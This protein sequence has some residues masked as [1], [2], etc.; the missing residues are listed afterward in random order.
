MSEQSR[1]KSST[2]NPPNRGQA[3]PTD[4]IKVESQRVWLQPSQ[5]WSS[6][7]TLMLLVFGLLLL[8]ALLLSVFST[9]PSLGVSSQSASTDLDESTPEN[10]QPIE[11]S[12]PWQRQREAQARVDAQDILSEMLNI[13]KD[14]EEV[15]VQRWA[16]LQYQAALALA[17]SGD[18]SYK[19][20]AYEE[21]L[22]Q[23]QSALAAMKAMREYKPRVVAE[24][25]DQG[26]QALEDGKVSLA[27]DLFER[28]KAIDGN[29]IPALTGL[30]RTQSLPQVLRLEAKAQDAIVKY[31]ASR[32]LDHLV[33]AKTDLEQASTLDTRVQAVADLLQDVNEM[34]A[35]H[36]FTNA[37]SD[38]LNALFARRYAQ[39]QQGF[40]AALSIKPDDRVALDGLQQAL[41]LNRN[42]SLV[43]LYAQATQH[44]D[45]ERWQQ[46]A[47]TYQ[48]LLN[49]D[50]AQVKARTS[51]VQAQVRAQLDAKL[52]QIKAAPMDVTVDSKRN[53]IEQILASARAIK[54]SGSRLKAQIADIENLLQGSD[55]LVKLSVSSD[56]ATSVYLR[57]RGAKPIAYDPFTSKQLALKPGRYVFT[58]QRLGYQDVRQEVVIAPQQR[59]S[60]TVDIRCT[61]A[62]GGS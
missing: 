23:Y 20:Q 22:V 46:A 39:A 16:N 29:H 47:S 57:K 31:Q 45:A 41:A 53:E 50:Q 1:L 27:Q 36:K 52:E 43:S 3:D 18:D 10:T 11:G 56:G 25:T 51:L 12:L 4:A 26:Q 15:G 49:R 32:E 33:L 40:S 24:L 14:L 55:Q 5:W 54:N 7:L 42:S 58:G 8:A 38:A 48:E 19:L 44:E 37:M 61:V 13:K 35:E 21:A 34:I 60:A 6:Q 28:A 59:S 17:E 62:L 9:P 2:Y 30:A